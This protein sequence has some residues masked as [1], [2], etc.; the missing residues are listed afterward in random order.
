MLTAEVLMT[1]FPLLIGNTA[2][3]A[4]G[5]V[6]FIE[7]EKARIMGNEIPMRKTESGHFSIKITAPVTGMDFVRAGATKKKWKSDS[8][9][10][11]P[12]EKNDYIYFKN[13]SELEGHVPE[14]DVSHEAEVQGEGRGVPFY[15]RM[16]AR[17]DRL[18]VTPKALTTGSSPTAPC[19]V[20][21][22]PGCEEM[23]QEGDQE[24]QDVRDDGQEVEEVMQQGLEQN[25]DVGLKSHDVIQYRDTNGVVRGKVLGRA[26]KAKGPPNKLMEVLQSGQYEIPEGLKN[27]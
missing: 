21:A 25:D 9:Q 2:M 5:A 8:I 23:G 27:E 15:G 13:K 26:G 6:L 18:E 14:S 7:E 22:G 24:G 3:T 4:A 20:R 17:G 19:T 10:E 12:G 16:V 1:S 11:L